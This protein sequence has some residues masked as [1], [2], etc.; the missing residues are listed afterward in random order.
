[1]SKDNKMQM[2][3]GKSFKMRQTMSA[4][5][6]ETPIYD[7]PNHANLTRTTWFDQWTLAIAPDFNARVQ[8]AM[9]RQNMRRHIIELLHESKAVRAKI[10][11]LILLLKPEVKFYFRIVHDQIYI[12]RCHVKTITRQNSSKYMILS[13]KKYEF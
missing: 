12:W 6:T 2:I 5:A 3:N 8:V 7:Y 9:K 4:P 13:M 10:K 1:M 11:N